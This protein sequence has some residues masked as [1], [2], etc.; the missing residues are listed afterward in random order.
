M[1]GQADPG[2]TA[3][4]PADLPDAVVRYAA[5]PDGLLDVHLPPAPA[6][7][8]KGLVVLIHGGFWK[9][10]YDRTHT[11][12]MAVALAREGF[13]VVTPEYRR[14]GGTGALAGGWPATA[15]DVEAALTAAPAALAGLGLPTAPARTVVVGHSAG[16]HLALWL[17]T[18]G[19]DIGRVVA[20]A[21]VGDLR[22]AAR[23]RLGDRAVQ[24]F[25]GG[26]PSQ[27]PGR[28]DEADP[29]TLLHRHPGCE[30][31][32]VHGDLDEDVPV[33]HSRGLVAAHRFVELRELPGTG[34]MDL[35]D[36]STPAWPAVL[37]A[38]A[39]AP[40]R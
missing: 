29:A 37:D 19:H 34:H 40:L 26:E 5:H 13:V 15:D 31:V 2:A 12:P 7:R 32:V 21:P 6:T 22:A 28:Y 27:V 8:D 20:L 35:V 23:D 18:R 11:R 30:V 4:V 25:L 33:A 10:A 9:A 39:G 3:G 17:A 38:I 24:A 1:D 36:P 16:G 14:V